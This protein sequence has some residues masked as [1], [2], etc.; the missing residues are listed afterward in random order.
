MISER[1]F[2]GGLDPG[3][4]Y[5]LGQH[6]KIEF[7][8]DSVSIWLYDEDGRFGIPRVTLEAQGPDWDTKLLQAN[9]SFSSGRNID[10]SGP[11][12]ARPS[13]DE[14]G[15]LSIFAG[16]PVSFRC[17]EPFRHWNVTYD[18]D[19]LDTTA[20]AQAAGAVGDAPRTKVG[21][22]LDVTMAAPPWISGQ[23]SVEADEKLEET[24]SIFVGG[25]KTF[26]EGMRYEQL[27][28]ATGTVRVGDDEWDFTGSGIRVRR[29]GLRNLQG[30]EGHVW[31]SAVFPS[32]RGFGLMWLLPND[33]KEAY[34]YV[35]GRMIP[36]RIVEVSWLTRMVPSGEDV[37]F[38]LE[39]EL[40]RTEISAKTAYSVFIPEGEAFPTE[41]SW[42]LY[43][44]Q[45]GVEFT[46]DGESAYGMMERSSSPD[47]VTR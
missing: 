33:Y 37:S 31:Q 23:M 25:R 29:Q 46:W 45:S 7:M 22:D 10:G 20:E 15:N 42:P 19:G 40:G 9:F 11:V 47:K 13:L 24:D 36:A 41:G 34:L 8:R 12:A 38:V 18:G 32:G 14:D 27:V 1:D 3:Y 16:G 43:W 26:E 35:D 6:P 17:V 2:S 5:G 21:F 39:S 44:Q 30:F 4:E 28:R